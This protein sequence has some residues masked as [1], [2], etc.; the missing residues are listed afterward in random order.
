[1]REGKPSAT[2][3]LIAKSQ[4]LLLDDGRRHL[5][6]NAEQ[7]FYYRLFVEA[8]EHRAWHPNSIYK[9]I[10]RYAERL[11]IPGIYLHYALR[12]RKIENVASEFL[13]TA[14]VQQVVVIAAG[15]DP[16]AAILAKR[17]PNAAF[18]ELD[19]PATQRVKKAA[20]NGLEPGGKPKLIPVDITQQSIA[21]EIS[22][23]AFSPDSPTLF[24]AE[25]ITM[26]LDGEQLHTFLRQIRACNRH[27]GS[28]LL[29]TYMNKRPNGAIQ[30]E[31]ASW[32]A[33]LW[34]RI[35]NERFKW[36]IEVAALPT[37]LAR[38]GY[39]F[40]SSS[41]TSN[42]DGGDSITA[43]RQVV[44]RGENICLARMAY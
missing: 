4:L 16:L 7:A 41:D 35:K 21:D 26:Y 39:I 23:T 14:R 38:Q 30:F 12:K 28:H 6:P 18:F 25:G 9:A 32:L 15:F 34:L 27:V 37:F 5:G 11:S 44:A 13:C 2:A 3:L 17:Y 36:G 20:L 43:Q 42:F 22:L 1:M 10:L 29:F 8:A 19:H 24:I 33:D 40:V 31:S